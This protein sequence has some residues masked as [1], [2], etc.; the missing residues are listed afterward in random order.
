MKGVGSG[1]VKKKGKLFLLEAVDVNLERCDGE[2]R[3]LLDAL[4]E[5]AVKSNKLEL[6]Q[7]L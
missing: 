2:L 1:V 3:L 7:G 6:E 4:N 5:I